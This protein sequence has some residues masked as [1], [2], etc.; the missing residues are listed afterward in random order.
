MKKIAIALVALLAAPAF[1]QTP[2]PPSDTVKNVTEK[3]VMLDFAGTPVD[4]SYKA[5]GTFAGM[6]GQLAGTWKADGKKLCI[7][8]P[9]MVENQCTEYPDG[10]QPGDSFEIAGEQGAMKVTINK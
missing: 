2:A 9:G 1:A 7:T 10:K 8:I 3:G 6:G 5:D 4:I